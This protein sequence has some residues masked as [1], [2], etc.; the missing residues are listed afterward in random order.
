M[1]PPLE[2]PATAASIGVCLKWVQSINE[3]GDD[4]FATTSAADQAAL[5]MALR[6]AETIGG[7]VKV[8][9]VGPD[10]AV[11]ALRSAIATGAHQ[12]IHLHTTH[13]LDSATVASELANELLDCRWIWCGDYSLDRGTGSVPAFLAARLAMP[14][15]L[16]VVASEPFAAHARAARAPTA[17]GSTGGLRVTR[18]LDG[19]RREILTLPTGGV[20]SVEGSIVRLRRAAMSALLAADRVQ[21]HTRHVTTTDQ[22]ALPYPV[23]YRPRA[24]ALA[25]PHEIAPLDRLRA[26]T[27]SA[28]VPTRGETIYVPPAEAAQRIVDALRTWGYAQ[29]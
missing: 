12:A 28:G 11:R 24:R 18:R 17:A 26:L 25:A 20:V 15:A 14:Q 22:L 1:T 23:A 13:H 29:P 10:G 19:G 8:V 5:E 27:D 2:N 16:G 21:I 7:S 6:Q 3:P 4:R 9:S